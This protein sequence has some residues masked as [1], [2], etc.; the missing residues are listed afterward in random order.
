MQTI[1]FLPN[2]STWDEWNGQLVHFFGEQQF[3]VL[4]E[5]RWQEVANS[6]TVN[7]VFDRYGIPDA[8]G[9]SSWQEWALC[10]TF[11]VNGDGA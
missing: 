5:E 2:Y 8:Y 7:P 4:P 9:F 6:V 3:P 11:A 10:L 1:D